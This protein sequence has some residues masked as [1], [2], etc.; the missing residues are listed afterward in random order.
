VNGHVEAKYNPSTSTWSDLEF[1]ASP[2][3]KIHGMAPG[4][5][6]GMQCYEG[7]KA[8]RTADDQNINVFR[9]DQN[10][11]RMQNSAKYV[12]MVAPPEDFFV[13]AVNM[14]V[15][16]NAEFVPPHASGCS[17]YIRPVLYCS[18]PQLGL[19]DTPEEISFCVSC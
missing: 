17:M 16:K 7:L 2:Y 13:K 10:A 11:K 12:S 14:A 19:D 9:P 1:V 4:L 3:V 8:F 15:A 6:Y 18:S 5:H